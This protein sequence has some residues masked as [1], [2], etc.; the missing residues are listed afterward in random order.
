[1]IHAVH[2]KILVPWYILLGHRREF[3]L[4]VYGRTAS[5]VKRRVSTVA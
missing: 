4:C 5:K 2:L 3:P 1:M